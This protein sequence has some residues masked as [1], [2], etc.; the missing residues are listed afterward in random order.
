MAAQLQQQNNELLQRDHEL[1]LAKNQLEEMKVQLQM[2][3]LQLDA[4]AQQDQ[5]LV[6]V[7]K[8]EAET[9]RTEADEGLKIAQTVKTYAE[10]DQISAPKV[11]VTVGVIP[12]GMR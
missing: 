11:D 7:A 8:V 2:Q 6:D 9:Q 3:R 5:L 10:A 12:D 4:K 1:K